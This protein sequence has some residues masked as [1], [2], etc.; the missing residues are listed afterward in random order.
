MS[1]RELVHDHTFI[2]DG[3]NYDVWKIRMLSH[4]R[5]IDP[6]MERIVDIGFSPPMDSQNLSLED[7]KKLYLNAQASN[8]LVHA[9]S[10][11]D[12]LAILPFSGAL[13]IYG[14]SFKKNMMCPTLLRMIVFPPL[15][16]MMNFHPLHH[17][18][19]RHKEMP[20]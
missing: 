18:V 17:C 2:F 14:Q 8:V 7:E 19:S 9:L 13:M 3:T 20:R 4:F 6:H 5:A 12:I 16:A 15:P 11:V 1:A 10:N